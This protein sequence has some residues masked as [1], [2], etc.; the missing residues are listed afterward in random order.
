MWSRKRA[1]TPAG[2]GAALD[3]IRTEG[4]RA[5]GPLAVDPGALEAAFL[6]RFQKLEIAAHSAEAQELLSGV[7]AA[8]LY[9]AAAC[10]GGDERAW[11]LLTGSFGPR[12]I[13]LA[14]RRGLP[15]TQAS[16]LV[17]EI[18]GELALPPPRG[19]TR[20]RLGTYL[21]AGSLFGWLATIVVRRIADEMRRRKPTSLDADP[22]VAATAAA[23][24]TDP[25]Q[26]ASDEES[27]ERAAEALT[28]AWT[29]LTPRERLVLALK[30]RDGLA[31]RSAARL[32]G[33]GEP[34][35]S[36]L[37][38]QALGKVR[39][40]LVQAVDGVEDRQ[41]PAL[42]DAI[43]TRLAILAAELRPPDAEPHP[44]GADDGS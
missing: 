21:G 2:T 34:R 6:A 32:L 3:R 5:H 11:E 43:R 35:V 36:R 44:P 10:E 42:R 39:A 38:G 22:A 19:G 12:L 17:D 26:A 33:I 30:F 27:A 24:G 8:G 20:T 41:W 40:A 13:G 25:S 31:Q 18:L 15:P 7:D 37:V 14:V 9:L 23:A 29:N 16:G 1:T 28:H 4:R